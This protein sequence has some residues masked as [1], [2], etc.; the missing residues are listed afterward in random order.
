MRMAYTSQW[1]YIWV[2]FLSSSS[3]WSKNQI[4]THTHRHFFSI[5]SVL[6]KKKQR[7]AVN[8]M[9][10]STYTYFKVQT[11]QF[12]TGCNSN[13]N[14]DIYWFV[15][16]SSRV[17][18]LHILPFFFPRIANALHRSKAK[19]MKIPMCLLKLQFFKWQ[20]LFMILLIF[21]IEQ[22]NEQFQYNHKI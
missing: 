5:K 6:Q 13:S 16:E 10:S 3:F 20:C 21:S 22:H 18:L 7:I 17:D 4:H 12:S 1:H 8:L 14:Y 15:F 11:N 9:T 2:A 19:D